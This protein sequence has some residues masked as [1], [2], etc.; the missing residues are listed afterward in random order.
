VSDEVVN[1]RSHMRRTGKLYLGLRVSDRMITKV[2]RISELSQMARAEVRLRSLLSARWDARAAQAAT[3][4]AKMAS[5]LKPAKD[6]TSAVD[7][8]MGG[9]AKDVEDI[10]LVEMRQFYRLGRILGHKKA[11]R[12]ITRQLRYD[13]PDESP[14]TKVP[15]LATVEDVTKAAVKAELLPAFDVVDDEALAAL[16]KNQKFWIGSHYSK[17][18]ADEIGKVTRDTMIAAGKDR[19]VAGKLM[20]E[21]LKAVLG[22]VKT[23]A[24]FKGTSSQYFEGLVANA[25][26]VGRVHGQMSSFMSIGITRYKIVNPGGSR[27][28]PVCAHLNGTVFETRWGAEQM[29]AELAAKK[30]E[31]IKRLH[32]WRSLKQVKEIAPKSGAE[33]GGAIGKQEKGLADAGMSLPPYHYR[34]RCNVDVDE[35]IGSYDQLTPMTPPTPTV[36]AKPKVMPPTAPKPP[37]T[38]TAP[39]VQGKLSPDDV[40]VQRMLASH[41]ESSTKLGKG[42]NQASKAVLR[43][44]DGKKTTVVLKYAD[45]ERMLIRESTG[46]KG[47]TYHQ[48]EAAFY[49]LDRELGGKTLT[50]PTVSHDFGS[51]LGK[52]SAQKWVDGAKVANKTIGNALANVPESQARRMFLLDAISAND[53]RHTLNA[54]YKTVGKRTDLIAIDNGLTFPLKP[55]GRFLF[56]KA[57]HNLQDLIQLDSATH[58]MVK[59][60]DLNRVA[61]ILDANGIEETAARAALIRI[62]ALQGN[63]KIIFQQTHSLGGSKVERVS[64]YVLNFIEAS[65]KAPTRL[66]SK[67]ALGEVDDVLAKL[68]KSKAAVKA[69]TPPKVA[70]VSPKKVPPKPTTPKP[71]PA[72]PPKPP[73]ELKPVPPP[74][75]PPKPAP[76]VFDDKKQKW[77]AGLS[78]SEKS[79][80]RAWQGDWYEDIRDFDRLGDAAKVA[81]GAQEKHKA[82][83]AA[84]KRAP[85]FEGEVWRGFSQLDIEFVE[86]LMQRGYIF[87][88]D[89]LASWSQSKRVARG[90]AGGLAKPKTMNVVMRVKTKKGVDIANVVEDS[91]GFAQAEQE[92]ILAKGSKF[93]VVGVTKELDKNRVWLDME[94]ID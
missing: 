79:A 83:V 88:Q 86:K 11:H 72:P 64:D 40:I 28:C 51:G 1:L 78:S 7:E 66:L 31:D 73:P 17:N 34:C 20:H 56:A 80:L 85:K 57:E 21:R 54:L 38:G 23:P 81:K 14:G 27:I 35:Q 61:A 50:P 25:A 3:I 82:L 68:A 9:W 29:G 75:P 52:A 55:T 71:K 18:V 74:E 91:A 48:R 37:V 63:A 43:A 76:S 4:A 49:Q 90:F 47:G 5:Q 60:L 12:Q 33:R 59:G 26:T 41:V 65:H 89:A 46:I 45:D 15:K 42:V 22:T 16:Q 70:Q 8:I 32:P 77:A 24:G 58:S 10:F 44:P 67:S 53:D 30:P 19:K 69:P 84:M 62:R 93:R 36:P 94:E 13:V 87:E 39:P 6:I 92:V 2:L